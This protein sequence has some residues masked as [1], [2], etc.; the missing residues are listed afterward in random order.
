MSAREAD[1][2]VEGEVERDG[3]GAPGGLAGAY[4]ER[5]KEAKRSRV[6]QQ[7]PELEPELGGHQ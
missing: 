7:Q 2:N 1:G 3:R 6:Q 5:Q 4:L